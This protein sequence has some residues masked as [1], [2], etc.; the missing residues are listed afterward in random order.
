MKLTLATFAALAGLAK[1]EIA[2]NYTDSLVASAIKCSGTG[3][4]LFSDPIDCTGEP[5][6]A[7]QLATSIAAPNS[8]DLIIMLSSEINLVTQTR[9]KDSNKPNLRHLQKTSATAE[10]GII[11]TMKFCKKSQCPT[12]AI[13][14]CGKDDGE[15]GVYE[16]LPKGGITFAS[17]KQELDVDV[18]LECECTV[19]ETTCDCEVTGYVEVGLNLDTTSANSFNFIANLTEVGTGSTADPIVPVACFK[20]SAEAETMLD[21][22]TGSAAGA[23]GYVGLQKSMLIVQEAST[24]NLM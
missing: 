8:K 11:A 15:D 13:G 6:A 4:E 22:E 20:L 23:L 24:S 9:V 10:A 1:S 12:T 2:Y 17:R 5:M 18:N 14:I 7:Y 3:L 16:A 19:P 21:D